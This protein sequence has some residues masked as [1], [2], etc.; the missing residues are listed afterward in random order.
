MA[1]PRH[2]KDTKTFAEETY[3]EQAK[4]I[5]ASINNLYNAIKHHVDDARRRSQTRQKCIGQVRRLLAR[6]NQIP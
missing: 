3:A 6:I 4:T 1:K 2:K 5:T